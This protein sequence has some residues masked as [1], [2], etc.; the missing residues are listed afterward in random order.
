MGLRAR[1]SI[2][3]APGVKVN[4]STKSV[5]L[6]FGGKGATYSVN[7]SGR[8]TTTVGIPGTGISYTSSKKKYSAAKTKKK[9]LEQN[10]AKMD[11]EQQK[12]YELE[13]AQATVEE[14]ETKIEAITSIHR[15]CAEVI[16]WEDIINTPAPF[17]F[18]T[19]GPREIEAR[20]FSQTYSGI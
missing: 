9:Q 5:G 18:G 4:L 19:Q 2:K 15:F 3:I 6:S 13:Y 16:P 11:K 12:R 7:S 20:F 1:K 10:I 8:R 17:E 14:Y